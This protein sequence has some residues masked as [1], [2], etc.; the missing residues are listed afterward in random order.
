[1]GAIAL[2]LRYRLGPGPADAQIVGE[3]DPL[4]EERVDDRTERPPR[5]DLAALAE[6]DASPLRASALQERAQERGLSQTGLPADRPVPAAA[7]SSSAP[8]A[9]ISASRP[10]S[11]GQRIRRSTGAVASTAISSGPLP[12]RRSSGA[13]GHST[14]NTAGGRSIPFSVTG[15]AVIGATSFGTRARTTSLTSS[16]PGPAVWASRAATITAA[17]TYWPSCGSGSPAWMPI[18]IFIGR[19]GRT[20]EYRS[21]SRR[22]A[23]AHVTAARVDVKTT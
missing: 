12:G 13:R 19:S 3:R 14:A 5:L 16:S 22:I 15:R 6:Q 7:A 9:A 8:S 1:M 17:P 20:L 11:V 4:G 23:I 18:P 2:E 21:A 10:T